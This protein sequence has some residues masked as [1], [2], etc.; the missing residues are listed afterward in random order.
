M[1][2]QTKKAD[3]PSKAGAVELT[4]ERLDTA[5]GGADHRL[6]QQDQTVQY[7]PTVQF[8]V[9]ELTVAKPVPYP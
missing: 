2:K 8:N 6:V 4:E 1:T 3:K 9:K 5:S 7:S